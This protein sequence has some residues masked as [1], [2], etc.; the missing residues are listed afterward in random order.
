MNIGYEKG[1][2]QSSMP[3]DHYAYKKWIENFTTVKQ[4]RVEIH[5]SLWKSNE[6]LVAATHAIGETNAW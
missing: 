2:K 5:I 3:N 6:N 4:T 1:G